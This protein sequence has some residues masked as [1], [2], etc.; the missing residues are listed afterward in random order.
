MDAKETLTPRMLKAARLLGSGKGNGVVAQ[1]L[2]VTTQTIRNWLRVPAFR[3]ERDAA[4]DEFIADV[5]PEAINVFVEQMRDVE[6]K[7]KTGWLRQNAARAMVSTL[8][9][10][11]TSDTQVNIVL[12]N[13]MEKPGMPAK[14]YAEDGSESGD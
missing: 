13:G 8:Q 9:S 5:V 1:E 14:E 11:K 12:G 7:D 3:A 2:G 10:M 6:G 4:M